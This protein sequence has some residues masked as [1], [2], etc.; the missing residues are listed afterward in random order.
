V[1]LTRYNPR[2]LALPARPAPGP[3]ILMSATQSS[4]RNADI[5]AMAHCMA[6]AR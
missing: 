1:K 5:Q 3:D 6:H 2:R 4:V